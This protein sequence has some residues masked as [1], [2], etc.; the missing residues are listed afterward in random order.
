MA[1]LPT[2]FNTL[3]LRALSGTILIVDEAHEFGPYMEAQLQRLLQFQSMLGGSA[4]VMTATLP[5]G[6]RDGYAK[7]F[8]EGLRVRRP[9]DV[10]GDAYP[11]LTVVGRGIDSRRPDPVPSTCRDV[12][13]NTRPFTGSPVQPP[14]SRGCSA[15][16]LPSQSPPVT[17]PR[18]RAGP[19]SPGRPTGS[20]GAAWP[21]R[22]W[23]Q[24]GRGQGRC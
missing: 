6:T 14:G 9:R 18:S 4:I 17:C 20:S 23:P 15:A 12:R 19:R 24:A 2:R 7:A 5:I 3:R 16:C 10:A 11:M 21:R 13:T 22:L 8:Q 1:V